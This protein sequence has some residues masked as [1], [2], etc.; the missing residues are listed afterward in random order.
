M[1]NQYQC[2]KASTLAARLA[3]TIKQARALKLG[4]VP[5]KE[6]DGVKKDKDHGSRRTIA[7]R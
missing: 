5:D 7:E 3:L 1:E 6:E 2:Y 4:E